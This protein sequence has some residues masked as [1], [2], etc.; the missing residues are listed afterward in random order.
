MSR[1]LLLIVMKLFLM[2]HGEASWEAET[3]ADRQLTFHGREKVKQTIQN[4]SLRNSF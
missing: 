2:R 3:D 1:F 4:L